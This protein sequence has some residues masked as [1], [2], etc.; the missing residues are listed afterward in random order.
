MLKRKTQRRS[1]RK[2]DPN[3]RLLGPAQLLCR[4]DGVGNGLVESAAQQEAHVAHCLRDIAR[5]ESMD[6]CDASTSFDSTSQGS[7]LESKE[8]SL[9][10][11]AI[12]GSPAALL[13]ATRKE[14]GEFNTNPNANPNL[15]MSAPFKT[16]DAFTEQ[17]LMASSVIASDSLDARPATQ[18]SVSEVSSTAGKG[19]GSYP[20][21]SP[22]RRASDDSEGQTSVLA[23]EEK[24]K[25][26]EGPH[27]DFVLQDQKETEV[28][29]SEAA[30]SVDLLTLTATDTASGV[31][32]KGCGEGTVEV[33]KKSIGTQSLPEETQSQAESLGKVVVEVGLREK[34]V[35]P[36]PKE[37][38]AHAMN[39]TGLMSQ[40][41]SQ[42]NLRAKVPS[43]LGLGEFQIDSYLP[44]VVKQL[45]NSREEGLGD[46][47]KEV[48]L[49]TSFQRYAGRLYLLVGYNDGFHVWDVSS[50]TSA[51]K[52]KE[53]LSIRSGCG[54]RI[55]RF[56]AELSNQTDRRSRDKHGAQLLED[57][58][59]LLAVVNETE[60]EEE[61]GGQDSEQSANIV[62]VYSLA[63]NRWAHQIPF[64][65]KVHGVQSNA[66]LV[67]IA[68]KDVLFAFDAATLGKQV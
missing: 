53:V 45:T 18:H 1:R 46:N 61:T 11:V 10:P 28:L 29:E 15:R 21:A 42:M 35:S 12:E 31:S 37:V 19:L 52:V 20:T 4:N 54:A 41:R 22:N 67:F 23:V 64:E 40:L 44:G 56:L 2:R 63:W 3:A 43:V 50:C 14:Y 68:L 62:R 47:K 6:T 60:D 49:W 33:V 8:S 25:D 58:R 17:Q 38:A 27:E 13:R 32:E 36:A 30:Q 9:K 24:E 57:A 16:V 5:S 34:R 66:R 48:I 55:V 7:S 51:A 26:E 39:K 59:P 65:S